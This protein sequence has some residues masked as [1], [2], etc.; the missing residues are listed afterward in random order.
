[1]SNELKAIA[2]LSIIM[3]NKNP[4]DVANVLA[5]LLTPDVIEKLLEGKITATKPT[6]LI[7]AAL[8]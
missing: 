2:L 4:Q 8:R 5:N 6:K 1:L 3:E 7:S